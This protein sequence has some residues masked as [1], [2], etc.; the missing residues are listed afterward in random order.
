MNSDPQAPKSPIK[1]VVFDLG[2]V[3]LDFDYRVA[4]ES[5]ARLSHVSARTINDFIDQSPLLHRY[6]KGQIS[7]DDFFKEIRQMSGYRGSLADFSE[8]FSEVFTPIEAMIDL[9]Q[10]LVAAGMPTYIFSNTNDLAIRHI[11]A[12]YPFY[13]SCAG[14]ILSYEH[15]FMKPEA[16]L[17]EAVERLTGCRETDILYF[18]DRDENIAA[19]QRRGWN[20]ILHH[21]VENSLRSAAAIGL[22][23]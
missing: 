11:R 16:E 20:S 23:R 7:G 3:L 13:H 10:R 4:A 17:Y 1:V 9:Q 21:S 12:T 22:L 8:L 5:L 14:H 15:G 19:A 18:D 6:E 2:K